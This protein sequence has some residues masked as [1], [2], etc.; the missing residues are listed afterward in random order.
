MGKMEPDIWVPFPERSKHHASHLKMVE[1]M[2][3]TEGKMA[4]DY[5]VRFPGRASVDV[6]I[7][8][9]G[10]GRVMGRLKRLDHRVV[11]ETTIRNNEFDVHIFIIFDAIFEKGYLL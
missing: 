7:I 3:L 1:C 10:G 5:W 11:F 6:Y 8:E 9:E 4:Q 2:A